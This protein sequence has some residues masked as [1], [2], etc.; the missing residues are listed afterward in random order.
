MSQFL[1]AGSHKNTLLYYEG[2][3]KRCHNKINK[4]KNK[5]IKNKNAIIKPAMRYKLWLLLP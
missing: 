4:I 1:Y 2:K 5:K 3:G